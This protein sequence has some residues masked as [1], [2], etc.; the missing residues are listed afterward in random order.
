MEHPMPDTNI[1][2][3]VA[4]PVQAERARV[5][6]ITEVTTRSRGFLPVGILDRLQQ[7]A[8]ADGW[9]PDRLREALWSVATG[10]GADLVHQMPPARPSE[11]DPNDPA[12]IRDAM[13]DAIAVRGMHG[14]APASPRHVE[15]LGLRPIQM[16]EALLKLRGEPIPSRDPLV[17]AERA[18]TTT[19]DF[20]ALLAAAANKM[21]LAGY[22]PAEPTYRTVF[23]RRDFRD[24]RPHHHL[25]LG[26]FPALALLREGG[27]IQVGTIS[28]SRE[29]ILL[30]TFARRVR[31][32]RQMLV[33]DD[34][35]AFTDFAAM[36]GRRIA[37]FENA[38]A[39]ALLNTAT[40]DGPTLAT[41]NAPV[42]A[43]GA[44]R[45]NKAATG[46]A[47]DLSSLAAGRAAIMQ[48]RS[49]D[50]MPI[51]IGDRMRLLVGPNLELPARQLTVV[52][53]ADQIGRENIFAGLI[54]PVVEPLIPANRWYVFADPET[55]PVYVYGHLDGATQPRV[56]TG[57]VQGV[58][59]VEISV[60]F[61]F[62][63]GAVD[64]RGAWFNPGT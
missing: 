26:D 51:T 54:D 47:L 10:D 42:F 60:V 43:M 63:V 1:P 56:T 30:S 37:D 49:L 57:P 13:A 2:A 11:P 23:R 38:T 27:E 44:S 29:S 62:G 12:V 39:Y 32:T 48:Q 46:S 28:E 24:F 5:A 7:R 41:G 40:G 21:L 50:G 14:Y 16:A 3:G 55:A 59:G 9:S 34:L 18:L 53:D 31:V 35:G 17:I 4:N 19:A 36:I 64:W 15:F 25:R 58:D 8:F 61:D 20:P 33:N 22:A 45:A 52:V 6:A